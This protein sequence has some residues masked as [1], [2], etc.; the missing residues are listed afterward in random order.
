MKTLI[1]MRHAKAE[2][3]Q[4]GQEDID[5]AL[6]ERGQ[7]DAAA[8]GDWLRA[9]GHMP[10]RALVS[11]AERTQQTWEALKLADTCPVSMKRELYSTA[12]STLISALAKQQGA[13]LLLV[14]HNPETQT[15]LRHLLK[16]TDAAD[17][18]E[19][20]PTGATAVMAL[21]IDS[22]DALPGATA[23]LVDFVTPADLRGEE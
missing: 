21:D 7:A 6:S 23:R 4:D 11:A 3:R 1:L 22:W 15:V 19:S 8:L 5:R 13:T 17:K 16:G 10:E 9:R 2:P 14:G 12:P 20:F 18:A